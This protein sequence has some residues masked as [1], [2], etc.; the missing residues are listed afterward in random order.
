MLQYVLG[1]DIRESIVATPVREGVSEKVSTPV[2]GIT[3]KVLLQHLLYPSLH[4][5]SI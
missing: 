1:R 2:R 4:L 3:E 5:F